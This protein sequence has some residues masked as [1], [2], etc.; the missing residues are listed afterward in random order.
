MRLHQ[1]S[2]LTL[3][4]PVKNNPKMLSAKV[5]CYLH[6]LTLLSNVSEEAN[7]VDLDQADLSIHLLTKRLLKHFRIRQNQTTFAVIDALRV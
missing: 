2:S 5:V 6:L 4:A 7:S 1:R 3:K